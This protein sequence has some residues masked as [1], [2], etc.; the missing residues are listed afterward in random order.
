MIR[1]IKMSGQYYGV[2]LTDDLEKEMDEIAI[3][4]REGT[5]VIIV[6]ELED[7]EEL[8]IDSEVVE[9]VVRD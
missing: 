5:P 1:V 8:E 9:M 4:I 6:E 3:F 2:E 7:L